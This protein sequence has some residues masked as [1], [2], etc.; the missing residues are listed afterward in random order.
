[1]TDTPAPAADPT[2]PRPHPPTRLPRHRAAHRAIVRLD[3][4]CPDDDLEFHHFGSVVLVDGFAVATTPDLCQLLV[5]MGPRLWC[6]Q[7]VTPEDGELYLRALAGA[8]TG[9]YRLGALVEDDL[10]PPPTSG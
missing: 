4:Y 8:M 9:P 10:R 5:C 6:G 1:M 3:V 7:V 2:E